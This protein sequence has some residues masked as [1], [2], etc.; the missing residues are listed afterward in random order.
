ME[1]G[2]KTELKTVVVTAAVIR[3]GDKFLIAQRKKGS[4]QGMKWEFPGGKVEKGEHPE[5]CL[6]REI[7]EELGVDIEVR[8]IFQVVSYN[9]EHVHIIL[10]CYCCELLNGEPKD[11]DCQ[12][13]RWVTAGE[14]EQY[15]FAP[16]DEPVVA[17]IRAEAG[18]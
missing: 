10:L 7:R 8:D 4:H 5:A 14:M 18:L 12:D 9:Y 6:E 15:Q 13:F 1:T 11:I 16:A 3:R 17:K 2:T